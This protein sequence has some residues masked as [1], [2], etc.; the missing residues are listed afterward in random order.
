[1]ITKNESLWLTSGQE[2]ENKARA[3][4]LAVEFTR[5]EV[6]D[7]NGTT[8][9]LNLA[10]T[11]LINKVQDGEL[12]SHQLDPNDKNQRIINMVI[13]PKANFNAIEI[14]L[15]AKYGNTEFPHTYFRL[16]SPF[17]ARTI[18]NGGS[19]A[20]LKY[21]IRTSQYTDF[22]V[23]L[24]PE[25][26]YVTDKALETKTQNIS[27]MTKAEFFA[28][29]EQ[30][31]SN[32][33][34]SGFSEWGKHFDVSTTAVAINEGLW[35][36][37]QDIGT[38]KSEVLH[39][40]RR[41]LD[42]KGISTSE[43]PVVIVNG[44]ELML[45]AMERL[46]AGRTDYSPSIV[47]FPPA[48]DGLDKTDG[49]GRF[50][51][52]AEAIASGGNA[53]NKSVLSR[54]DYVFLEVWHEKISDKNIVYPLGNVQYADNQLLYS[55]Q[56]ESQ[57]SNQAITLKKDLVAQ[58]YS[59]FGSWDKKTLGYGA[60]WSDLTVNEQINFKQ[61]PA[62]NIY[63]D[64]NE[65]V[66]VRYRIRVLQGLGDNWYLPD[67]KHNENSALNYN[68]NA[69]INAQ[70][71]HLIAN[72][73]TQTHS[74]FLLLTGNDAWHKNVSKQKGL[75]VTSNHFEYAHNSMCYALPIALVQRRN[76]G[77]QH[78]VYNPSGCRVIWW[79]DAS[80]ASK[81]WLEKTYKLTSASECFD[82][83]GSPASSKVYINSG[84]II[85][86][87][88]WDNGRPDNKAFDAIYAS[89]VKDLRMSSN[90]VSKADINERYKRKAVAGMVRGF[91]AVPFTRFPALT[92]ANFSQSGW[93]NAIFSN[94]NTVG[95]T[96]SIHRHS[97]HK[98]TRPLVGDYVFGGKR[99]HKCVYSIENY[100]TIEFE[101]TKEEEPDL[102]TYLRA[103]I[104]AARPLR[105][106][107]ETKK[108]HKQAQ[109]TWTDIIGTP[110][111]LALA[112]PDGIEGRWIPELPDGTNKAYKLSRKCTIYHKK[113]ISDDKGLSWRASGQESFLNTIKNTYDW[114]PTSDTIILHHY[115]TPAH[116]TDNVNNA[117]I[118]ELGNIFASNAEHIEWGAL[119]VSS[120]TGKVP[121]SNSYNYAIESK[122]NNVGI[123]PKDG[124]LYSFWTSNNKHSSIEL[125]S[126]ITGVKTFN[127]LTENNGLFSL[128]HVYKEMK[129]N[130]TSWGD[131]NKFQIVDKQSSMTDDNGETVLFGTAGFDSQYFAWEE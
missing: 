56:S 78:P 111:N 7:A 75:A 57:G 87:Q 50:N 117:E 68:Q 101:V 40:G 104:A 89:D 65:L 17:A 27:A 13:S 116:F 114:A 51:D 74:N 21:T 35:T 72:D 63:L 66:Q 82:V 58:G 81:W 33:A 16:A 124:Q 44:I 19:Q 108:S 45:K 26:T 109:P 39:L 14:L 32:S 52:L 12:L 100:H 5:I 69:Y 20:K 99:Y 64:N 1:M 122:L 85:H 53:L 4:N 23:S 2:G 73:F 41:L 77:A 126:N 130:G 131:D 25:I 49:S 94:H 62:N 43:Y 79:H 24:V 30:R 46:I 110:D 97:M 29:A 121:T 112:F 54:Q 119:L 3:L 6:G 67:T 76:Q 128:N 84:A 120:L 91:E 95:N 71:S 15:Y 123:K 96:V 8:P 9:A 59:A 88:G 11:Q 47:E 92:V 10:S 118:L 70:G 37:H 90:K 36:H 106:V 103:E 55:N 93:T 42:S 60:K 61:N 18:E 86:K 98:S 115:Q 38:G 80:G 48:P 34:G 113:E 127:Y 107:L 28:L 102:V 22:N 105:F 31:K 129:H 83:G 125:P